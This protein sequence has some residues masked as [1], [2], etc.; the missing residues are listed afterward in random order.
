[1]KIRAQLTVIYRAN[2]NEHFVRN[3]LAAERAWLADYLK[4][5]W[6]G[7]SVKLKITS[8]KRAK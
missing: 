1:V 8:F 2:T 7:G 3:Q 6:P 5:T 4:F